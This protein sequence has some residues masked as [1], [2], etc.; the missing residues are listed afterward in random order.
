MSPSLMSYSQ[1]STASEETLLQGSARRLIADRNLRC[2]RVTE[3]RLWLTSSAQSDDEIPGDFWLKAGDVL[4]LSPG[5][6]V[7]I[8]A[9]P[10]AR[11]ALAPVKVLSASSSARAP[12]PLQR[13]VQKL[14]S[15]AVG[16]APCPQG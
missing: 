16:P 13:W 5:Q 12:Q 3:G 9:W 1:Q 6:E 2:L 14:R 15:F 4:I 7:V 11:F 8:E 10:S